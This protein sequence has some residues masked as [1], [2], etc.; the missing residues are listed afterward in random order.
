MV[1]LMNMDVR[2]AAATLLALTVMLVVVML[3]G[4]PAGKISRMTAGALIAM[5]GSRWRSIW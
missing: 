1:T 5:A 3:A 4:R 2:V